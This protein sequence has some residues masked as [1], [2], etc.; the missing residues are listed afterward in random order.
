[1]TDH[2]G[3]QRFL[4]QHRNLKQPPKDWRLRWWELCDE[5]GQLP[6]GTTMKRYIKENAP[7]ARQAFNYGSLGNATRHDN[8]RPVKPLLKERVIN[9]ID[10]LPLFQKS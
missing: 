2:A 1:M 4:N 8:I 9:N 7:G 10:D 6:P 3:Y 5:F